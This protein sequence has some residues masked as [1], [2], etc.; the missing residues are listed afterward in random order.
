MGLLSTCRINWARRTSWRWLDDTAFQ[1][2]NSTLEPWRSEAVHATSR[3]RRLPTNWI[4]TSERGRSILFLWN[5]N[6]RARF[7]NISRISEAILCTWCEHI[8]YCYSGV[9][10]VCL[11]NEAART[12][13]PVKGDDIFILSIC[14]ILQPSN[15]FICYFQFMRGIFTC[16]FDITLA[17]P[18]WI[19]VAMFNSNQHNVK[20]PARDCL[21]FYP[22]SW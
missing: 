12:P 10:K 7:E 11:H 1:T 4:F 3:S 13:F 18:G 14:H 15:T 9:E 2:Q 19:Y 17:P 16:Q 20:H 5:L 22:L 21:V 6:A 8:L